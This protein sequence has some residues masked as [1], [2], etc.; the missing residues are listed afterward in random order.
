VEGQLLGYLTALGIGGVLVALITGIFQR[1]KVS[2]DFVG[3]L[4]TA[5]ATL[6]QPLERSVARLEAT[7][8]AQEARHNREVAQLRDELEETRA[9]LRESRNDCE[10]A[11][12]L[13]TEQLEDARATVR[14]LLER[15]SA[16]DGVT[17]PPEPG[18]LDL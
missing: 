6:N 16:Q 2:G 18:T 3:S 14:H 7:L 10:A 11:T 4:A 9:D 13:L 15:M 5:A 8:D 1:R 12:G 17:E